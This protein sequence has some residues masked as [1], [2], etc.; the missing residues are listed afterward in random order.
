MIDKPAFCRTFLACSA[1]LLALAPLPA[2]AQRAPV[3][4]HISAKPLAAA[5]NELAQSTRTNILFS[6]D[7]VKGLRA[8]AVRGVLTPEKAARQLV[9]GTSLEVVRDDVGALIIR[10]RAEPGRARGEA[11]ARTPGVTAAVAAPVR[12]ASADARLTDLGVSVDGAQGTSVAAPI[13]DTGLAEIVVTAQKRAES[14]QDTP[15]SIAALGAADIERAGV[16]EISDLRSQVPTLQITPHPNSG[17]STRIFMRGVGNNDDQIT[18]D[19]SVAVYVDGVYVARTQG[20]ASEVAELERVE[21]LRGPQ[22]SLYGRNA[23]GGAINFITREPDLDDLRIKQTFTVGNYDHFRTRTNVNLPLADTIAVEL[24]YMHTER[25]GF[26]DNLGTGVERFGDQRRD[27]YRA[28]VLWQPSDDFNIRYTYDRSEISD[29]PIFMAQVPLFPGKGQRP[30]EGSPFVNNLK[31]NDVVAQG[32]NLT[33]TWD[34]ADSLTLK[35][36]TGYRKLD[37]QTYQNYHSGVLGPFALL[38]SSSLIHQD[39]FSQEFQA[40]GDAFDDRLR[41]VLGAYYFDEDADGFDV[42]RQPARRSASERTVTIGN[43]AYAV[44]GQ[45]TF[46]PSWLDERLHL[47]G[48][49][50]WSRDERKA[51]LQETL[52]PASGIPAVGPTTPASKAFENFSPTIVAAFD[53]TEDVNIYAKMVRGYKSGGFNTRASTLER[54]AEGF[55]P[56][57]LTSYELGF[58]STLLDKRLRL[59]IAAF[60]SDYKDIQVNLRSDPLNV[61]ITDVLNAG[62]AKVKGV[63]LDITV[64]PVDPL[65]ISFSYAYLNGDYKEVIDATGTDRSEFFRFINMAPNTITAKLDYQFP[66]TGIGQPGIYVDYYYQDR[67]TTSTSDPRY[68]APSYGLLD[69]RFTLSDIPIGFGS[70]RLSAFGRNLTDKEYY[71]AH[72]NSGVPSA[73][74]GQPRTYG[75]ELTFEY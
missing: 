13:D 24:G 60:M 2:A 63:E 19:P 15:I 22:G 11:A 53:V 20:M 68:Q 50:R 44:Y 26:V 6:P 43:R 58:K 31:R 29:T 74:F 34:V 70:W 56:E 35:S 37:N 42:S 30:S 33:A 64:R 10:K 21:V 9:L 52:I 3:A 7:A 69:L 28:G 48:G 65:T 55:G 75:L 12:I 67:I 5:L 45:A 57:T 71:I 39:Q 38:D 72:F 73:F 49:L 16:N 36:I 1:S 62:K 54:F 40:V 32:H 51:S 25:D 14:L 46:T 61:G 59:N 27:A 4:I 23:T 66:A 18:Q 8:T 41:Y 47:T 17:V